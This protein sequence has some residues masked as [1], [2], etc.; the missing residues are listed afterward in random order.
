M[1]VLSVDFGTSNTVAALAAPN[2]APR[3]VTFDAS[4]LLPSA[5]FVAADGSVTVGREAQRQARLDP[6]RYEPNPKRRIDDTEV[7]LGDRVV[8]VTD[9]IASVLRAVAVEVRRQLGGCRPDHIRLT[10]PAEWG[11]TRKAILLAAAK[12]AG[13]GRQ[14]VL[15]PEPVAAAAQYTE[16]SGRRLAEGGTVAVYD[17]GGGTFDVAVVRRSAG[18]FNVLAT[19]GLAD[20][21]GL[22]F[23]QEVLDHVGRTASATDPGRWKEI[24]RPSDSTSRRAARALAEDVRAAKETL[25]RYPQTD[26]ALPDPFTDAHLTRT[27]FEA[28]IRSNVLRSID[29]LQATLHN[30]AV[31]PES[32]SGVFLVGGSSRIPLV[33][34]LIAQQL[35][36]VPVALDQPETAVV[37]GALLIPVPAEPVGSGAHPVV[38]SRASLPSHQVSPTPPHPAVGPPSAGIPRPI[39]TSESGAQPAVTGS[40]SRPLPAALSS[41]PTPPPSQPTRPPSRPAV[42]THRP[43]AT[44][45]G[46]RIGYKVAI[47]MAVTV[48]LVTGT[49]LLIIRPWSTP[50]ITKQGAPITESVDPAATS[51]GPSNALTGA[52]YQFLGTGADQLNGCRDSTGSVKLPSQF[53]VH[54][55]VTCEVPASAKLNDVTMVLVTAESAPMAGSFL[56]HLK[57]NRG[58]IGDMPS[59]IGK[60]AD[61]EYHD[62]N[63]AITGRWVRVYGF[64]AWE[65]EG[66]DQ[67]QMFAWNRTGQPYVGLIVSRDWRQLD[68]MK[69]YAEQYLQP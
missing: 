59:E 26:V 49:I 22:D 28:L 8:A 15:I 29:V 33:A 30:A 16:M 66:I 39:P 64:Q 20:L 24:L 35:G 46:R 45:T 47:L 27:E 68:A 52:E 69:T 23:D 51:Y 61:G 25:S 37:L 21:G 42:P 4:P 9:L 63:G 6:A 1:R 3:T 5:V 56:S 36:I 55:M 10:Y 18:G 40:V 67:V 31:T 32:L 43:T 60:D 50:G 19:G 38:A 57:A 65:V 34:K 13:L 44:G 14:V 54:R 17:L 58:V 2:Q 48:L 7:L 12:A 53:T 11:S 62:A 41:R